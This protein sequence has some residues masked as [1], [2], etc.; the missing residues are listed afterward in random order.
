MASRFNFTYR[1]IDDDL[2]INNPG[3]ENY[4]GQMYLVEFGGEKEDLTQSLR[5]D[6]HV[7]RS[8]GA[9]TVIQLVRLNRFTGI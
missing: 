5:T 4:L 7:G 2:S 1:Y 9:T 3:F 6:L 8:F